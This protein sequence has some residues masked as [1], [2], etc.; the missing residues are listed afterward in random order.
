ML[1]KKYYTEWT[2]VINPKPHYIGTSEK[3][4][5]IRFLGADPDGKTGGMLSRIRENIPGKF[6]SIEHLGLVNCDTDINDGRDI[7]EWAGRLENYSY[8]EVDGKTLF[9]LDAELLLYLYSKAKR[10]CCRGVPEQSGKNRNSFKTQHCFIL[11]D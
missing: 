5:E 2:A 7:D 4:S 6:V 1:D 10:S 8:M 3:G 11:L 9:L